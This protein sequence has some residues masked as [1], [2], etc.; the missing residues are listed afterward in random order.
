MA[1]ILASILW[2]NFMQFR[3]VHPPAIHKL[4]IFIYNVNP[5]ALAFYGLSLPVVPF[6]LYAAIAFVEHISQL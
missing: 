5:A 4:S 6:N 1:L 3:S 2:F